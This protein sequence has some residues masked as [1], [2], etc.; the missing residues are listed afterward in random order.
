MGE[1][2]NVL[3]IMVDQLG[4]DHMEIGGDALSMMPTIRHLAENGLQF[5]N[6]YSEC[7]VCIP[8]R[9]SLMTGLSPKTH[10]DRIYN[11]T[12]RMPDAPTLA[13]T[14]REN[15]YQAYGVGK[16]HVYPQRNRIGFDD[17]MIIEEGRYEFGEVDDYQIWLAKQGYVGQEFMH[18]MGN[19]VY[20]T[21]PWHL[22]ERMHPTNWTTT[23][24]CEYIKRRDP[25]KPGFFYASYQYPHPPMVP[26]QSYLDMYKGK[27]KESIKGDWIGETDIIKRMTKSTKQYTEKEEEMAKQAYYAQCTHIDHQ[28]RLL[29]G[30]LRECGIL[31]QTIIVFCSDHGDMLFN[32]EMLAK[33][34]FYESSANIPMIIS[35]RPMM[36]RKGEV[37]HRLCCLQDVMPTLLELCEVKIPDTVEG[38]SMVSEQKREYLYGEVGEGIL[39]T[40]MLRSEDYKLIYY[41]Y[42]NVSQ[43]FDM[44]K[45][46]K[47]LH[48]CA[49][50]SELEQ[51]RKELEE[52]LVEHLYGG[53]CEWVKEGRL[54]GGDFS[55]EERNGKVDYGLYNQRG[56]HWPVPQG[57]SNLGKNI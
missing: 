56:F 27:V 28:I 1:K 37:D 13:Q 53:D 22:P 35:G 50:E 30:T 55:A 54:V 46:R 10:G 42:R 52:K 29:I 41:P 57:Y 3:M 20:Y 16:L 26:I 31:D 19:N 4:R 43:M 8:A 32:H 33:R 21:R 47:E 49:Q 39:A 24:M 38:I 25:E 17:A 12:L 15:G 14:F 5:D 9:R 23:K 48:D 34:C 45:D 51:I 18:G 40:R 2:N 11:D 44:R 36:S 7:P 6:C